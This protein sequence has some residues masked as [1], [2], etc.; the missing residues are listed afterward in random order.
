MAND[1]LDPQTEEA[2]RD[3]LDEAA[4]N[5]REDGIVSMANYLRKTYEAFHNTGFTEEQSYNFAVL[6]YSN[7]LSRG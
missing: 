5:V 3:A 7:L 6:L 2:V 1:G 4:Q